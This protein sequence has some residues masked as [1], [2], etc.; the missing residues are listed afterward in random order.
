MSILSHRTLLGLA[1][2]ATLVP[3]L[4]AEA[5][6]FGLQAAIMQPLATVNNFS[7]RTGFAV[8][9]TLELSL[10]AH[11]SL[12]PRF[13][14]T[15][16]PAQTTTLT[17]SPGDIISTDSVSSSGQHYYLGADY[18]IKPFTGS[19]GVYLFVGLGVCKTSLK[20]DWNYSSSSSEEVGTDQT[21]VGYCAGLGF[22]F[23]RQLSL[24]SKV[25]V[26][27]FNGLTVSW[28][29]LGASFKF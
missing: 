2:A 26:S 24:E 16:S 29:T 12:R 3:A 6:Q 17:T 25:T 11:Q 23:S 14:Y 27:D 21:R 15:K 8:A 28:A 9:A 5:P 1:V 4:A 7:N 13:E 20:Q 10:D 22:A 18:L 19:Q